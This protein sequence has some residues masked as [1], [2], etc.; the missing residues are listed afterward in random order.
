MW[1]L[2]RLFCLNCFGVVFWVACFRGVFMFTVLLLFMVLCN[3]IPAAVLL[4]YGIVVADL[5]CL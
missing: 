2:V 3:C 5:G 4:G 1:L